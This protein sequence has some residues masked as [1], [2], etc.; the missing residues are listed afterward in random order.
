[1]KI[2]FQLNSFLQRDCA[3]TQGY[4]LGCARDNIGGV[5]EVYIMELA[6]MATYTEA[7]GVITALTKTTGKRFYKYQQLRE[8]S[9]AKEQITGSNTAGT[10]FY[11]QT[12]TL[13][14]PKMQTSIRNEIKVMAS[15]GGIVAIVTTVEGTSFMYGA[16]NGLTLDDGQITTGKA[17]GD[18]NGYTI[19]LMGYER[20][21]AFTVQASVVALLETPA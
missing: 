14:I 12:V 17:K 13:V 2:S 6:N 7:S 1:V 11:D 21:P 18:L 4:T 16:V 19:N 5:K 10:V 9:E 8:T 3:L 20:Q 15:I